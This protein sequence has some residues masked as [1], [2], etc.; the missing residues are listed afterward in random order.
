MKVNPIH[1]K[2]N[3]QIGSAGGMIWIISITLFFALMLLYFANLPIFH[4]VGVGSAILAITGILLIN[5]IKML[6]FAI[7]LPAHQSDEDIKRGRSIRNWFLIIL[8]IEITG[9]NI[10]PVILIKSHCY[11]YIVPA[12]ILIVALHFIPLGRIF[13]MPVYYFLGITVSVIDLLVLFFI[14]ESLM[15]GNLIATLAIPT[16]SFIILN[17]VIV[18]Y[19]LKNG[20]KYQR[21]S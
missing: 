2:R 16:L 17:W 11:Q 3:A 15:I 19:I 5:S 14:P 6:R 21:I 13:H 8:A 7:K 12:E 18:F 10:A 1:Q 9:L 4:T 20:K